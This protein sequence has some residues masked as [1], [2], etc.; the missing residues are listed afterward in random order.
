VPDVVRPCDDRD[1]PRQIS[2]DRHRS[3]STDD[4]IESLLGASRVL[5]ALTAQAMAALDGDVTLGQYRALV[6][7]A[8]GPRRAGDLAE[9]LGVAPSTTTR[10][11]DRLVARGLMR[12]FR[13]ANDRRATWLALTPAGRDLVAAVMRQRR[14]SIA[15]Y[16]RRIPVT[17]AETPAQVLHAF[18]EAAGELSQSQWWQR[19]RVC[20]RIP[21]DAVLA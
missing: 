19:W 10:L 15:R 2:T 20:D 16:L 14:R 21:T 18:V 12:R 17:D 4:L 8:E 9:E 3:T 5:V 7:L 11:C 1:V 6:V 13:R